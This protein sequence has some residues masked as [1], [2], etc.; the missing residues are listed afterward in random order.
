MVCKTCGR[1][2][3]N[4]E[5]N[6]CEYCGGAY[7]EHMHPTVNTAPQIQM[8]TESDAGEKPIT[9]LNWLGSYGLLLIPFVGWLVY[10]VMLFV[11]SFGNNT[12]ASKKSWAKATLVFTAISIVVVIVLFIFYMVSFMKTPMFQDM[13]N[14]TFDYN[15][16]YNSLY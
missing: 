2:T 16:Y 12:P 9:F 7:R 10:L 14:G 4:E 8:M 1:N 6:F 3:Q 13:M 15:S 11:W 5:A